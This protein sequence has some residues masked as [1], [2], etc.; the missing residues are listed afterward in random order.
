MAA[1][2]RRIAAHSIV[3]L[4]TVPD[5][6]T[7]ERITHELLSRR[8]AAC[9]KQ[10]GP[11]RARFRWKGKLDEASEFVLLATTRAALVARATA[12]IVKLHPYE[13]PE[14]VALPIAAGAPSY[15]RW[16]AS[17]TRSTSETKS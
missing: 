11:V 15:L 1:S 6:R 12:A 13:V 10:L 7:G 9:V 2:R 3:V 5:E 17:E 14:V 4:V 16:I 8:L